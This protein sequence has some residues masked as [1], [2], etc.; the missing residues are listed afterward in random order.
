[1]SRIAG[2]YCKDSRYSSSMMTSKMLQAINTFPE[3]SLLTDSMEYGEVGWLGTSET[4]LQRTGSVIAVMDGHIFNRDDLGD[5]TSDV[6]LLITLYQKYG[7]EGAVQQLN[8]DFAISL[9]DKSSDTFWMARDRFGIKPL[10]FI[11]K[12][13][14]LACSSRL[15][16]FSVLPQ[17]SLEPRP[18]FVGR[19]AGSHYRYF[20]NDSDKSPF[21]GISQLEA[22]H[23]LCCKKGKTT[24]SRYWQ[25]N[26]EPDWTGSVEELAHKYRDLLL[27]S[28]SRRIK[29]VN[30][31]AFTLSGGMDSSSVMASAV[32]VAEKKQN[33]FSTVYADKTY[34]ESEEIVTMLDLCVE[35]WH[36]VHIDDNPDV[37]GLIEK[38]ISVHDEPVAT[39]T[40]LS[41]FLLCEETKNLGFGGLFGGLGGDELNA[42]EYEHFMFFFADLRVAGDEERLKNEVKMWR[43]YHNHPLY[44]KNFDVVEQNFRKVIDFNN[45]G[46][47]LPDKARVNYYAQA[48][49]P[50]F[51]DL[52]KYQPVM[53][54]PFR[55]YLK[56]R[57]YQDMTRETIPCCL[58]AEDRQATAFG[59]DNFLPFFDHRLVEFM[60]RVP[61]TLKY[62]EGVTKHLLRE[63]MRGILPEE[64]RTR[65][66]KTGW[67]AP[68]HVWFS[69]KRLDALRD[70]IGSSSFQNR[71]IYNITEVE[72][73]LDEHEEI[74]SSGIMKENHMMF[75]WQLVNL[76]IWFQSMNKAQVLKA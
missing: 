20:D 61:E 32:R 57:T 45:Q 67:N 49:N 46:H 73:L 28:V 29:V 24:I 71:G 50:D 22:A 10:Y 48:L 51:F 13:N 69:G 60:F 25:L 58:R 12:P 66:A 18:D 4:K 30:N 34:D 56:N 1:M 11:D 43:K 33:A 68:A 16:A 47:C 6:A 37:M 76:E 17:V 26:D 8:G 3:S 19:F 39:A 5:E 52:D 23:I 53:D 65:I 63:A 35:Q 75:F 41:H 42:G 72:R 7:F 55:S 15:K 27:D 21:K 74:V 70:L 38:M 9:Y 62:N 44:K 59:L 31:P 40:W 14:F 2:F 36:K 64:T 54:H